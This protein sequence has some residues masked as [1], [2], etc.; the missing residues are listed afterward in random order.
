MDVG[1]DVSEAVEDT[2]KDAK[3]AGAAKLM[4][5]KSF[6]PVPRPVWGQMK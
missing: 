2:P 6:S 5:I 1:D 3:K 4:L